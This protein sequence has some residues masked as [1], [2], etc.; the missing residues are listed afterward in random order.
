MSLYSVLC[1]SLLDRVPSERSPMGIPARRSRH[2][3]SAG[4]S[5]DSVQGTGQVMSRGGRGFCIVSKQGVVLAFNDRWPISLGSEG[6]EE[7]G[8]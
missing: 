4:L 3:V 5:R 1:P 6:L 8:N 7:S 2:S